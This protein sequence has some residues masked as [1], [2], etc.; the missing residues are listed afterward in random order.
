MQ[1]NE[2]CVVALC[3]FVEISVIGN[4]L[5]ILSSLKFHDMILSESELTVEPLQW[6]AI[7]TFCS[8]ICLKSQLLSY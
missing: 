5:C 4:S 8:Y 7:I 2:E 6:G 3:S 1:I